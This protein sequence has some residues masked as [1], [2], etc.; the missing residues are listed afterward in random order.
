MNMTSTRDGITLRGSAELVA[1][2]FCK[3]SSKFFNFYLIIFRLAALFYAVLTC[4][5]A[6]VST[7]RVRADFPVDIKTGF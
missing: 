6:R 1:E 4:Y 2:F 3:L 7:E 5:K